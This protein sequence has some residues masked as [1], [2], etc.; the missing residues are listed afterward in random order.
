METGGFD[1]RHST[2][3]SA[4]RF[5]DSDRKPGDPAERPFQEGYTMATASAAPGTVSYQSQKTASF[6]SSYP[7]SAPATSIPAGMSSSI[8]ARRTSDEAES[9]HRRSQ[10]SL[11][12]LQEVFLN[13]SS[14]SRDSPR[15]LH[16]PHSFPPRPPEPLSSFSTSARP[17]LSTRTTAP[18]PLPIFGVH[19]P[20]NQAFI[21]RDQETDQRQAAE[22]APQQLSGGYS[23]NFSQQHMATSQ[24]PAAL[25]PQAGQR[26]PGQ[27]PLPSL[28]RQPPSPR[29]PNPAGLSPLDS[30]RPPIHPDEDIARN[31]YEGALGRP[32][33]AYPYLDALNKIALSSRII[34]NFAEAF[35]VAAREQN[36]GAPIPSRLPNETE[37]TVMM[38][39]ASNIRQCLNDVK[40]MIQHNRVRTER[41][42][43]MVRDSVVRKPLEDEDVH[44]YND[45]S[46]APQQQHHPHHPHHPLNHQSAYTLA[47][48]KK[49]RGRAA[50]PGRC[51]SCNRV[52]TP[53]WRRG[54]DGARTLCNACGLHY[55]KLERKRQ[56][57]QRSIRPKPVHEP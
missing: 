38:D 32:F 11:P 7:H 54:P 19:P 50:P 6:S 45:P 56:S 26:P 57:E 30:G 52:D 51:H 29:Q 41:A 53:E 48:V 35:D 36:G 2:S 16:P 18:P 8:E 27:L 28:G 12:S 47:E 49:R 44:M 13:A 3:T 20:A 17:T 4:S 23:T 39:N 5:G 14:E 34:F 37:I 31:K 15:A 24:H 25:Y 21:G 40:S 9:T 43:D 1:S 10:H 55:A 33:D 22:V 42:R 46:K